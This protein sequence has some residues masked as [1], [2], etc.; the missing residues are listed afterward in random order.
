MQA[1]DEPG[2]DARDSV[3]RGFTWENIVSSRGS[4]S[5]IQARVPAH[6]ATGC[7]RSIK[8]RPGNYSKSLAKKYRSV[9]FSG[10]KNRARGIGRCRGSEGKG[11]MM[12]GISPCGSFGRFL[13]LRR[14]G[15]KRGEQL[16]Q[17]KTDNPRIFHELFYCSSGL[18]DFLVLLFC[19]FVARD[20]P[21]L[22]IL[23][24]EVL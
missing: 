3:K 2:P 13:A 16:V 18:P 17:R 8:F 9:P 12:D 10:E 14:I 6:P 20:Y 23:L 7:P 11:P 1:L 19:Q 4:E 21:F 22:L 5:F 24:A 15:W